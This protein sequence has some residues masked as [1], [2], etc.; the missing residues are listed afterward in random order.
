MILTPL[1]D[2]AP[3]LE[4]HFE[5]LSQLTYPHSSIDLAFLVGDCTDDTLEVLHAEIDRLQKESNLAQF[6]TAKVVLKDFGANFDQSVEDRHSFHAQGTRRRDIGRARNYL[7]YAALKPEHE[8]V[9]W[10]DVDIVENPPD[11]I[12]EFMQ[13]D[14]DVLVPSKLSWSSLYT[15]YYANTHR[16]MVP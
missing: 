8:W 6:R 2:A 1:R 12:E 10:R 9:Y 15:S 7:L 3:H 13:H 5:L 14:K 16:H 4:K 11:I